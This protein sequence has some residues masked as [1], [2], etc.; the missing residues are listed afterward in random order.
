MKKYTT[1]LL[2][3]IVLIGCS[4]KHIPYEKIRESFYQGSWERDD[5]WEIYRGHFQYLYLQEVVLGGKKEE[6]TE[7]GRWMKEYASWQSG[8]GQNRVRAEIAK[9]GFAYRLY[10]GELKEAHSIIERFSLPKNQISNI[11]RGVSVKIISDNPT[12][13]EKVK[14]LAREFDFSSEEAIKKGAEIREYNQQ[15]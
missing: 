4:N 15:E 3:A 8:D 10:K 6:A 11:A 2:L 1:F 14:L 12:D 7:A 13:R 9:L 5:F